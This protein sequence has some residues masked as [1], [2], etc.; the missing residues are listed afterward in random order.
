MGL[1]D[2]CPWPEGGPSLGNPSVQVEGLG[3]IPLAG[4]GEGSQAAFLLPLPSP[5]GRQ[6]AD[7]CSA[8]PGPS[9]PASFPSRTRLSLRGWKGQQPCLTCLLGLPGKV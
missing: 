9:R 7:S 6:R 5:L 1:E 3:P 2:L 4:T 8:A